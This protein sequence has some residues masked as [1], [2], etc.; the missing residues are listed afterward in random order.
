MDYLQTID[1]CAQLLFDRLGKCEIAMVLG[2]GLGA[3]ENMLEDPKILPYGELPGFPISTV[4]GHAGHFAAGML[5]GKRVL[6]MCG[7]VHYYEGYSLQ[8]I[9]LPIRVMAKAGV[10]KLILTNAAGGVNFNFQPPQL[11]LITDHINLSGANPLMGPNLDSFGPR[12]PDMTYVYDP[13]L[14]Q[15]A[16]NCAQKLG[17]SLQEG[18]YCWLSGPS[19][20]TPAEIRMVRALGADAVGMSTVP[21]AIVAV[22]SRMRVLGFSCI[23]NL[24]AGMTNQAL[25]HQEVIENGLKIQKDFSQLLCS[26][27]QNMK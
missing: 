6:L 27:I 15:F 5:G 12:F 9:T 17:I 7:R 24:A 21:E 2:S 11:M 25:T 20:E 14:M 3:L 10:K 8:Q 19:Y 1:Q 13:E 16:R 22:H 4:K 18:V 26:I 23:S